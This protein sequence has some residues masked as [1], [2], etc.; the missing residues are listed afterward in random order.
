MKS[1]NSARRKT[2]RNM[3]MSFLSCS[4]S[5][6]YY[7]STQGIILDFSLTHLEYQHRSGTSEV[8][9]QVFCDNPVGLIKIREREQSSYRGHT[10]RP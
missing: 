8:R 9:K 10:I 6:K 5:K 1:E 2:M 4:S 7:N 3:I